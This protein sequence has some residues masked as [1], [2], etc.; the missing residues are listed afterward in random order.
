M[1]RRLE[2][3]GEVIVN[4]KIGKENKQNLNGNRLRTHANPLDF[5]SVQ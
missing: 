4:R 5:V 2:E 1:F 3:E